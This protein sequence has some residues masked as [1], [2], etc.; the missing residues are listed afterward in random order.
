MLRRASAALMTAILMSGCGGDDGVDLP[1]PAQIEK[2]GNGDNQRATAG[3]RL[4]VPFEILVTASDGA[5]VP[6]EKLIWT[7]S[8]GTG[9]I[10]SDT[11]SVTDGTGIAQA[12]LTLGPEAGEYVVQAS[13]ARKRDATITFA[14]HAAPAPVLSEVDPGS[15][16]SGDVVTIR[17]SFITDSTI[18]EFDGKQAAIQYEQID[19]Q[20]YQQ[21]FVLDLGQQKLPQQEKQIVR[22]SGS[23]ACVSCSFSFMRYSMVADNSYR[24]SALHSRPNGVYYVVGAGMETHRF[25]ELECTPTICRSGIS[26]RMDRNCSPRR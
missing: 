6:R 3:N 17:G 21:V 4:A 8:L 9:A 22:L 15:F 10:L 1:I 11:V 13:L 25:K 12:F 19:L 26:H 14:A 24:Y 2:V 16:T 5:A 7:V 20:Q 18:I 23:Y